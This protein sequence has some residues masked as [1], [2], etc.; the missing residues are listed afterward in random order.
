MNGMLMEMIV[1]DL[2]KGKNNTIYIFKKFVSLYD[3]QSGIICAKRSDVPSARCCV[4]G[5]ALK[6]A[7]GRL[8]DKKGAI[9]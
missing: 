6:M 8:A 3:R 2:Q 7:G 5:V 1:A 4:W 9:I